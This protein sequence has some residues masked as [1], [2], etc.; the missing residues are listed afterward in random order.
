M[1]GQSDGMEREW[2]YPNWSNIWAF[3]LRD[4]GKPRGTIGLSNSSLFMFRR[5]TEYIIIN[6]KYLLFCNYNLSPNF[7]S[8]N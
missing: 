7:L 8:V 2:S 6:V 4:L 1:T 3:A 5:C